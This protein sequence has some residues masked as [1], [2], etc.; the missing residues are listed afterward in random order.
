VCHAI[1]AGDVRQRL[2]V[3]APPASLGL[4]V[5]RQLRR[6]THVNAA[7]FGTRSP[8][9]SAGPDKLAPEFGKTVYCDECKKDRTHNVPGAMEKFHS[10][11]KKYTPGPELKKRRCKMYGLR[12]KILHGSDLMQLD[13]GRVLGW[14]PPWWKEQEMNRELLGSDAFG[15]DLLAWELSEDGRGQLDAIATAETAEIDGP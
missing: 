13:Q 6:A 5:R 2:T 8:L 4:L 15:A 7:G 14:D 12:S 11:F 1:R 3:V 10:V 9:A